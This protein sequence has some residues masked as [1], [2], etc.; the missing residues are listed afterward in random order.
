MALCFKWLFTSQGGVTG[1][2]LYASDSI[3]VSLYFKLE[4][5][6]S[7]SEIEFNALIIELTLPCR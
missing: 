3:D 1:V 6:C 7:S 4:F 5:R 2:V